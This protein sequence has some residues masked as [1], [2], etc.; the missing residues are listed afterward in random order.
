MRPSS[1]LRTGRAAGREREVSGSAPAQAGRRGR[2][3]LQVWVSPSALARGKLAT[4]APRVRRGRGRLCSKH[5]SPRRVP[6]CLPLP[7]RNRKLHRR[8]RRLFHRCHRRSTGRGR[9]WDKGARPR[10]P[11]PPR[12]P[13]LLRPPGTKP[14]QRLLQEAGRGLGVSCTRRLWL[15]GRGRRPR[16]AVPGRQA[17]S[18]PCRLALRLPS[19]LLPPQPLSPHRTRFRLGQCESMSRPHC[20]E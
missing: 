17:F 19:P 15:V 18:H 3:R 13:S 11:C 10:L 9:R 5:S 12:H 16:G 2:I 1:V 4:R 8:F 7:P 6:Q 14:S 20:K